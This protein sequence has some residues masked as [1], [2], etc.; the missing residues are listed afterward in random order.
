[1]T[2]LRRLAK[3]G[4][5]PCCKISVGRGVTVRRRYLG[6]MYLLAHYKERPDVYEYKQGKKGRAGKVGLLMNILN[7]RTGGN[8]KGSKPLGT[9]PPWHHLPGRH[10]YTLPRERCLS[11]GV[12]L[13]GAACFS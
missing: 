8:G 10:I 12:T 3:T 11:T 13:E 1:M 2:T 4:Y 6:R 5:V 9:P 7:V